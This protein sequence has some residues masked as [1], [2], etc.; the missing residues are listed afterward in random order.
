MKVEFV[1]SQRE[2]HGVQPVLEALKQ[3]PAQI[4]PSTYYAA[5]TRPE[6]ARAARDR[7]LADKI[8]QVHEDNYSVYGARKVWAELNRQGTDVARC[9]VERV[10]AENP[11][12][13]GH[14]AF[15][16]SLR[17][18]PRRWRLRTSSRVIWSGSVMGGGS[19]V[20]GRAFAMPW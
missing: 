3:T 10:P 15:S 13:A 6:S 14:A 11:V 1:D 19:G 16:Y 18:P 8:E 7:E 5:K 20:H 9:T 12:H 2:Q 17:I 4:A